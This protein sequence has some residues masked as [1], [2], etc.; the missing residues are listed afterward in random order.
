MIKKHKHTGNQGL[1]KPT[2]KQINKYKL[3]KYTGTIT[4]NKQTKVIQISK[5]KIT[6]RRL[7]IE[8]NKQVSKQTNTNMYAN[9]DI[10]II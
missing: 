9:T 5:D 10:I 6:A 7:W 2:N 4:T 3:I 1:N 8:Q